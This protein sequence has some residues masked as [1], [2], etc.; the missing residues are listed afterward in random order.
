MYPCWSMTGRSSSEERAGPDDGEVDDDDGALAAL[1]ASAAASAA[2][3]TTLRRCIDGPKAPPLDAFVEFG[4][5]VAK[6][7][8]VA[9][10][11]EAR[12]DDI[13][14]ALAD[15]AVAETAVVDDDTDID[16]DIRA[17]G[18]AVVVF[19]MAAATLRDMPAEVPPR[20]RELA[21]ICLD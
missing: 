7:D 11:R 6:S 5:A 18:L 19:S 2:H 4:T 21:R 17:I 9:R 15:A 13:G 20:E 16:E 1:A 12:D 8:A 10:E 3:L 14:A